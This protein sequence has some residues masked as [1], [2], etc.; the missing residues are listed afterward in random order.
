MKNTTI[1]ITGG[2]TSPAL[3]VIQELLK[4][5]NSSIYF[6]GRPYAFSE[7]KEVVSFEFKAV[8]ELGVTFV[9][10]VAP[11]FPHAFTF[12]TIKYPFQLAYAIAQS[13]QKLSSHRPSC[14]VSFGGYVGAPVV[15]AGWL[16]G[17]PVVIH[18]QTLVPGK[19][20]K[21]LS[22]FAREIY[23]SWEDSKHHFP[24][25]VRKKCIV[26]GNPVRNEIRELIGNI[27]FPKQAKRIYIT[28]GSTGAHRVNIIIEQSLADLTSQYFLV[29]QCGDSYYRDYERLV[30][31]KE[32]LSNELSK[33]YHVFNYVDS[34]KLQDVL[35]CT[36][37]L[38]GRSGA[39][40]VV[41][42]AVLGIPA[43]FIPLPE[44]EGKEQYKQAE[45]MVK[46][47]GS[48]LITQNQLT[49]DTLKAALTT[50]SKSIT[51]YHQHAYTFSKTESIRIHAGAHK[52]IVDHLSSFMGRR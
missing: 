42:T 35:Q 25:T 23:L 12:R 32:T 7:A 20:N 17:I 37:I 13:L 31:K 48:I 8:K 16:L 5:G 28:G 21:L 19:A 3:A 30:K 49:P 40:T 44:S 24:S 2:H 45:M 15:I 52:T 33:N 6:Y 39:N 18:E 47:A 26:T 36:D 43:I 10:I 50:I 1:V 41:E 51:T 9:S 27:S 46:Q 11:R 38:V 34:K 4:R 29:H 22:R 14:I